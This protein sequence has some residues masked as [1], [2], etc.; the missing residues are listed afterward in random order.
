MFS[1]SQSIL[2]TT[3]HERCKRSAVPGHMMKETR[4]NG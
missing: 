2:L 3:R 1:D 4:Q